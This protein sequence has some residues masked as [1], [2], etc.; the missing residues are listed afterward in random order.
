[1]SS[2]KKV[3]AKIK[4][5]HPGYDLWENG[6]YPF[7][8]LMLDCPDGTTWSYNIL[9]LVEQ[10]LETGKPQAD[11]PNQYLDEFVEEQKKDREVLQ[12]IINQYLGV[13]ND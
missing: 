2:F 12:N 1:M 7:R 11:Y 9:Y 10:H 5:N 8:V 13:C 4:K 6:G 3:L